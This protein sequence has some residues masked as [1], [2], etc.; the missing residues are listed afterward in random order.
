VRSRPCL[1][2]EYVSDKGNTQGRH[3]EGDMGTQ[4]LEMGCL[5]KAME[6]VKDKAII[7]GVEVLTSSITLRQVLPMNF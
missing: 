7:N 4:G 5:T 2:T 1:P 6:L 3:I